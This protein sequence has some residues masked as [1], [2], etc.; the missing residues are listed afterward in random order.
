[1]KRKAQMKSVLQQPVWN[2]LSK[3]YL[4]QNNQIINN[5]NHFI[6]APLKYNFMGT[7]LTEWNSSMYGRAHF[8]TW[9][10][11]SSAYKSLTYIKLE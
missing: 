9:A 10:C 1:M 5:Q 6:R 11:V 8:R 2:R 3:T 4:T 7:Q